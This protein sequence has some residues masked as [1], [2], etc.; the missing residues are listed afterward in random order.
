M[1]SRRQWARGL[2]N[3]SDLAAMLLQN[4]LISRRQLRALEESDK[5][6]SA[7][8][9]E[10]ATRTEERQTAAQ[11]Q[12]FLKEALLKVA[13]GD[14]EPDQFA[15][16]FKG[17]AGVDTQLEGLRP[18]PRRRVA[19]IG[20]EF[21]V[22]P[23]NIPE[24]VSRFVRAESAKRGIEPDLP[25]LAFSFPFV[26]PG[27]QDVERPELAPIKESLTARRDVARSQRTPTGFETVVGPTGEKGTQ[28]MFPEELSALTPHQRTFRTEATGEELGKRAVTQRQTESGLGLPQLEGEATKTEKLA[29][30]LSPEV[31]Q[32]EAR[33]AGRTTAAQQA[34][35]LPPWQW[36][37][38]AEGQTMY[39]RPTP[40]DTKLDE[41]E[42]GA[43][44]NAEAG[45]QS[46]K[47]SMGILQSLDP[48]LTQERGLAGRV[49]GRAQQWWARLTG[50]NDPVVVYDAISESMLASLARSSREVG[51]L[52]QQEQV[53]YQRLAPKVSDPVNVRQAKYAAIQYIIDNAS[54]GARADQLSPFLDYMQFAQQGGGPAPAGGT[55]LDRLR[56]GAQ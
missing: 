1:P 3:V 12:Q 25:G 32:A 19:D 17:D 9:E 16:L 49:A 46:L 6:I 35:Q 29:G 14:L 26:S 7:R 24:D 37:V 43:G 31:Q 5:R 54:S 34:A 56:G 53:R 51:N 52:A 27:G 45:I 28:Y 36:V 13:V 20:K 8:Q 50:E 30:D 15:G 33:G 18:S 41:S 42:A 47:T 11:R 40:T 21:D 39:R 22:A 38:T 55:A 44:R 10:A 2:S 23:L 48:V 4:E